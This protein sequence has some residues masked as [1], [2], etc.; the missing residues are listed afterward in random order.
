MPLNPL[1]YD[2]LRQ[3]FGRV[4]IFDP[5]S[6]FVARPNHDITAG[7]AQLSIANSGEY[8]IVSCPFC[9][10]TR[11]RLWVNHRFGTPD[12]VSGRPMLFLAICYNE[13]C[14]TDY[15]NRRQLD[16]WVYGFQNR[17]A[18][19]SIRILP[20][21][22]EE[23]CL[24][25]ASLPGECIPVEQLPPD[26]HALQYMCGARGYPLDLLV[27][28]GC[29]FCVQAQP[30]F[31]P[32]QERIIIPIYMDGILVGWQARYVGDIDFK[33]RSIP[34]YYSMPN[35]AKRQILYN[36]DVAKTYPFVTLVEGVTD[37]WA[38]GPWSV[39]LLGKTLSRQQEC[40]LRC[41]WQGKP[42]IV[43]LD[44]GEAE[45]SGMQHIVEQL[46]P[47]TRSPVLYVRLPAG[48]DPGS[49]QGQQETLMNIVFIQARQAGVTLPIFQ[50]PTVTQGHL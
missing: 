15:A 1:L 50:P 27:R 5:G 11:K 38:T 44:G 30:R 24:G 43:M 26:H 20:G 40:L 34:K 32:A 35:M 12:P 48:R 42:I 14:L 13:S 4:E 47:Q 17:N 23:A 7:R 31:F 39:A 37:V 29:S 49:Y 6:R 36:F 41:Q 3:L 8:Y 28:L 22:Y 33:A 16:E 46:L 18:R 10:D 2:R 25:P 21:H 45:L 9:N 19:D